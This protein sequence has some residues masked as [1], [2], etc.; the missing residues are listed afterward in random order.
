MSVR[1]LDSDSDSAEDIFYPL[2]EERLY[3]AETDRPLAAV[4]LPAQRPMVGKFHP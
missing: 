3:Q 4:F 2:D 1:H